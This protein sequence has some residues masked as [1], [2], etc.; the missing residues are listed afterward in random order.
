MD[1]HARDLLALTLLP[2]LGP[3]RIARLLE[4][5]ASPGA[6]L[7]A[8][9]PALARVPGIGPKTARAVAEAARNLDALLEKE[10]G[11]VD[12]AGVTLLAR[13]TTDYPALLNDLPGAPP[14][15]YA[16][17]SRDPDLFRYPVAIVGSRACTAYGIEQAEHFAS[18]L[19]RA[20]L[21]IVSGG[22]RGID[23]AAHRG[24]L[25]AEGR[26]IAVLGCGLGH[27]YPPENRDLFDRIADRGGLLLS[28]L[29]MDTPPDRSNFPARNRLISGLSLGVIVIEAAK[30]S[31]ALITARHAGEDHGREVMALPGRVDSPASEGSH[32][33]LKAGGAHVVTEP[34]DVLQILESA[35]WHAHRGSLDAFVPEPEPLAPDSGTPDAALFELLATPRTLDQ[36]I[37][38][39]SLEPHLVTAA[40]TRLEL[41]GRLKR[42]RGV[43]HRV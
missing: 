13:G 30:G 9:E 31:G 25:R 32:A 22:A 37:A 24:A 27:T 16:R 29:P 11:R 43:L 28:E 41:L 19:A 18:T 2:G 12:R 35:G 26:T 36:L 20:G 3:V 8:S 21:T 42:R 23:T 39:S 40:V 5:F 38:D 34:G 14:L 7:G 10:L 17:G 1:Q 4:S 6:A 33:L 15:L